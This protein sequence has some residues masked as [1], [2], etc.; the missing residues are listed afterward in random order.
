M[1]CLDPVYG[2]DIYIT[3][4]KKTTIATKDVRGY[5]V[6]TVYVGS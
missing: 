5:Y 6:S 1:F 2:P 3:R 4:Q